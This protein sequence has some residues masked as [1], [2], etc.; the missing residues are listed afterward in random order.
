[1][2]FLSAL[3]RITR[4]NLG[5]ELLHGL[6]A[7]TLGG[8]I[9]LAQVV[10]VGSLGDTG[11][12]VTIMVAAMPACALLLPLWAAA[13]HRY[14]LQH[15]AVVSG[16]LRCLPFLAVG[17]VDHALV[18]AGLVVLYYLFGGAH[19]LAVP[20][21]YKYTYPD[22]HRGRVL[23]WLRWTQHLVAVPV[24]LG[25]AWLLDREPMSFQF[26]FPFGGVIGLLGMFAYAAIH[27]PHDDPKARAEVVELPSVGA[28]IRV[29]RQDTGFRIFQTTIFLT[30]AGFM[31][32]RPIWL[33]LLRHP[34]PTLGFGLSGLEVS[35]LVMVMPLALGGLTAPFWGAL[36][37]RTSP[38]A[39]RIA[40]AWMGLFAYL[41]MFISFWWHWLALAYVAAILRGVVLGA[42]ELATT[43]GNLYF[44]ARAER[45]ALYEA[46]SAVSQ[47]LRGMSMPFLGQL[48]F[49]LISVQVFLVAML[50]NVWSLVLA[51]RLWRLDAR[52]RLPVLA[53]PTDA[54]F[55]AADRPT[56]F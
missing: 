15:L 8:L 37:D 53:S 5:F 1:M 26:L 16:T 39:G 50:L 20:A 31:M 3:P 29:W 49:Q 55:R 23:G 13:A 47:G 32:T 21:L 30:G 2:Y 44:A 54:A 35:L 17:W 42:A 45:A 14:R 18:L 56:P 27:I 25:G 28:L 22:S 38:V 11:L 46:V 24:V 33:V 7:G 48:L 10:A 52:Q 19:A 34:D 4:W 6:A 43:T 41:A 36:I 51:V 9:L 40:F 12:A